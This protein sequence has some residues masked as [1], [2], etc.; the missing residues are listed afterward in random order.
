MKPTS[1]L[2][3]LLAA[4]ML[5]ACNPQN[6]RLDA[7]TFRA[8]G[9]AASAFTRSDVTPEQEATL[10]HES[11]A[12]LLGAAPLLADPETQRYVSTLGHW[13]ARQTG[14]SDI[15]WRF[16]VLDSP[17]I[18]AFAAPDGYVFITAGL[19][20]RLA[21]ESELAGILAHEMAHVTRRHYVLA[22]QKKDTANALGGLA[23][24]AARASGNRYAETAG[25]PLFNLAQGIYSSG[26]DKGDE[27]EADRLGVVYA[28]RAGFDPY[29]L[30][31]VLTMYAVHSGEAGFDLLFSTH[32]S[33]QDRLARLAP[34]ME[35]Q[36]A[37]LG[38]TGTVSAPG[39][40]RAIS[41]VR[42]RMGV[43]YR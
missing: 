4:L 42:G 3:P 30:P 16:G 22:M 24:A 7:D 31:R 20:A 34:P 18:N 12:M 23:G 35:T 37:A 13:I 26:L 39:F 2:V 38:A 21:D 32:P 1:P 10:G 14:R 40:E 17:N 27:Y 28:A 25:T 6:I 15:R 11:A 5:A 9:N 8:V 41:R 29:G 43:P 19:L 36:L 33:P